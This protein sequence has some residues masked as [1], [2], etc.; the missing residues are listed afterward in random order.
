MVRSVRLRVTAHD[1]PPASTPGRPRGSRELLSTPLTAPPRAC[2]VAL[3]WFLIDALTHLTV[4]LSYVFVTAAHGGAK[5][6]PS[7]AAYLWRE[8]G[9]ADARWALYDPTVLS[10]ELLTVFVAGPLALACAYGIWARKPWRHLVCVILSV[11]ELYGGVM[12][13]GPGACAG[14]RWIGG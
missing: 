9:R 14:R 5:H 10:L 4:E 11:M 13:F 7:P 1:G 8:Y 3:V 12:T 6:S 2:S